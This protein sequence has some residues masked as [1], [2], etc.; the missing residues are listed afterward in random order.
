MNILYHHRTQGCGVEGVHINEVVN[1]LKS[2]GHNVDVLSPAGLNYNAEAVSDKTMRSVIFRFITKSLPEFM[3]ELMEIVYNYVSYRNISRQIK[4]NK[5]DFI[6]ERYAIFGIAGALAARKY[7][8]PILCEINYTSWSPLVR[9]RSALLMPF[10]KYIDKRIFSMSSGLIAVSTFLKEQLIE[11]GADAQKV[12]V[13]P[14]AADPDK[15]DPAKVNET[16]RETLGLV[17]KKVLGFIGGFY[18]WH[19]LDFLLEGFIEIKKEYPETALLLIGDGPMRSIVQNS[20]K[21][22]GV[23]KDVCFPG[24]VPHSK[25]SNYMACFDVAI[26]PD[27]NEYGSPMKIF[28][29]MAME[30]AVIAPKLGPLEDGI[31]NGQEGLLFEPKNKAA[32]LTALKSIFADD[33]KRIEMGRNGR[34]NIISNHTWRHNAETI[35]CAYCKYIERNTKK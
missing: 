26:M 12:F 20:A 8:V 18:P 21:K 7:S 35:I 19:G 22:A 33:Q 24:N 16:I 32:F 13:T 34:R 29:Y 11:K 15:F 17:G 27:S 5:Y 23:E 4:T 6:Y 1:A 10:A 3:F 25:L 31:T 2:L 14:N 30:R 9:K 28:E